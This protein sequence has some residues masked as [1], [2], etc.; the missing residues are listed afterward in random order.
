MECNVP[1]QPDHKKR[2]RGLKLLLGRMRGQNF[3]VWFS[4]GVLT[5]AVLIRWVEF[6]GEEGG[7][8]VH[9]AKRADLPLHWSGSA[10]Y[11]PLRISGFTSN[12]NNISAVLNSVMLD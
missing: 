6:G 7:K 8:E 5:A 2:T 12:I 3:W 9:K 4:P 11:R 1:V 10:A